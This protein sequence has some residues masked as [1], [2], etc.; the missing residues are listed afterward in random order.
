MSKDNSR[1]GP[2]VCPDS[3]DLL[4]SVSRLLRQGLYWQSHVAGLRLDFSF[5]FFEISSHC[6]PTGQELSL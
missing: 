3:Q 1:A 6:L 5:F 2:S 4:N